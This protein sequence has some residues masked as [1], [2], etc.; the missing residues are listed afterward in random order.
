MKSVQAWVCMLA[1]IP[2]Q[3]YSTVYQPIFNTLE[4]DTRLLQFYLLA[5]NSAALRNCV[6]GADTVVDAWGAIAPV[7]NM[8][9][10]LGNWKNSSVYTKFYAQQALLPIF[11]MVQQAAKQYPI[12]SGVITARDPKG[13]VRT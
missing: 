13:P 4:Q 7:Y 3:G 12:N 8:T 6:N 9:V 1:G 2:T 11:D 5:N 10:A